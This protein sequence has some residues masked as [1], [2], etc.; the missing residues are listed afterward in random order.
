M[1]FLVFLRTYFVKVN[2]FSSMKKLRSTNLVTIQYCGLDDSYSLFLNRIK[3]KHIGMFF[4]KRNIS[5]RYII[6]SIQ[7]PICY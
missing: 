7:S 3:S 5:T 1:V 4:E 2:I 6:M